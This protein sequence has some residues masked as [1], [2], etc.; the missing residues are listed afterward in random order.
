MKCKQSRFYHAPTLANN[1]SKHIEGGICAQHGEISNKTEAL[2][3]YVYDE[4]FIQQTTKTETL[5]RT[6]FMIIANNILIKL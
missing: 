2:D 6:L 4:N 5:A 1:Y 3:K